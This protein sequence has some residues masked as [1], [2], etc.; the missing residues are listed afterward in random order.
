MHTPGPW[1][2]IAEA[3][4]DSRGNSIAMVVGGS[5]DRVKQSKATQKA[6]AAIAAARGEGVQA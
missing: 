6:R 1:E 5:G 4:E 3:V 2:L